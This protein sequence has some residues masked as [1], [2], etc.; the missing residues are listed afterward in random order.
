MAGGISRNV[1]Y[2]DCAPDD[3]SPAKHLEV[4]VDVLKLDSLDGVLNFSLLG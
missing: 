1:E 2:N 3:V 4:L